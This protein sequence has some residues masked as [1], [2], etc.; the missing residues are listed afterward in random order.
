[1]LKDKKFYNKIL[2]LILIVILLFILG[3]NLLHYDPILGYD[4]EAHFAYVDTF[5]RY[6]PREIHLP[7]E[8]ETRE[9]FNPP[10][11]YLFPS[12]I[13]VICRN[14]AESENFVE[15]CK[16]IYSKTTQVF[17]NLLY[18]TSIYI[19]LL[20]LKKIGTNKLTN[21]IYLLLTMMLAVNYRTISMI[22][23][24]VYILFFLSLLVHRFLILEN[25]NFDY[26]KR[27]VLYFGLLIG[28]L[29]LS[30]QW[31][32]LI[33]PSF[34]IVFVT[35]KKYRKSYFKFISF[36]FFVGFILSSWFYFYNLINYGSLVAF[37]SKRESDFSLMRFQEL[38]SFNEAGSYL[39]NNPI[40][41]YFGNNFFPIL[42]SDTWGDY[43][44]YFSFTSRFL[45][46]GRNQMEIGSYLGNVNL[47]SLFT[48]LVILIF[49]IR[50]LRNN[51]GF[52]TIKIMH[53]SVIISLLGYFLFVFL[54]PAGNSGDTI[55]ATYMV[56]VINL[57]VFISSIS[58]Q[59]IK[60][61]KVYLLLTS[62]LIL[63]FSYN[64]QTYL[65]HFPI[66]YPN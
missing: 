47:L 41:P 36:S 46:I 29:A 12:A 33:F 18:I 45:A 23:G 22:R 44:G 16:P 59:D 7:T 35:L 66:F 53:Y 28:A 10:L 57:S 1:M 26:T 4:A 52:L 61:K 3:Y 62:C 13:Q 64:F 6:L 21:V 50:T 63:I 25:K 65:S 54:Y 43:W 34:F 32:F 51:P 27:D 20:T 5:S 58:I 24:E 55:K 17:Q 9:F 60:N 30:R 8:K 2:V 11:T 19:N 31:S 38:I 14:V 49:Y 39:F 42:Y 40:R 56:Q 48:A 37:N 15:Y